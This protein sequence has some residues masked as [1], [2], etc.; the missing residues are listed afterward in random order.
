MKTIRSLILLGL[1]LVA[2][3]VS[4]L[5]LLVACSVLWK[6]YHSYYGFD[7][8]EWLAIGKAIRQDSARR[9]LFNAREGMAADIVAHYLRPTMS[10]Q[11]VE[12]LLGPVDAEY[13]PHDNLLAQPLHR[14]YYHIWTQALIQAHSRLYSLQAGRW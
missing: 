1:K 5:F 9:D 2:V 8:Q 6:K 4:L 14:V 3:G 11:D 10:R 7:Q 13:P 12:K